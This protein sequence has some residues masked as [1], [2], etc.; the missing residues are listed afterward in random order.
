MSY[1]EIKLNIRYVFLIIKDAKIHFFSFS[2]TDS[3]AKS[4]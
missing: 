3:D 1:L 2:D 4:K